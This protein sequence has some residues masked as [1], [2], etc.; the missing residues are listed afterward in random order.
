MKINIID[1]KFRNQ[2]E[3]DFWNARLDFA[4]K[5]QLKMDIPRAGNFIT[6]T[7][8]YADDALIAFRERRYK[9]E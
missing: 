5:D 9:E 4:E 1:M 3:E 2:I 8:K 7:V 6:E